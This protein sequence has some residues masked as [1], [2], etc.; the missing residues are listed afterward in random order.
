LNG[1]QRHSLAIEGMN[2]PLIGADPEERCE[3]LRHRPDMP[4]SWIVAGVVPGS[5]GELANTP[6]HVCGIDGTKVRFQGTVAG[7]R[8]TLAT[9]AYKPGAAILVASAKRG[10]R[11]TT[12]FPDQ[13]V[14]GEADR[15][16]AAHA[17]I[18]ARMLP[19]IAATQSGEVMNWVAI[20]PTA[21]VV[22]LLCRRARLK[23]T[24]AA[25]LLALLGGDVAAGIGSE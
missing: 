6:Q 20:Q 12:D 14:D 16:A 13:S 15:V 18:I 8:H 17:A 24:A 11:A 10:A 25:R 4:D 7:H 23:E 19:T 9:A 22:L 21:A 5:Q 1:G 3:I 2:V